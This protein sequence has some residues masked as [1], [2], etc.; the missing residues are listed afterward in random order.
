MEAS[1]AGIYN[2][3][4]VDANLF[5]L[6]HHRAR[7][8]VTILLLREMLFADDAAIASHT[9]E[10]LQ[11][12][13][14]N[15]SRACKEFRVTISIKKTELMCQMTPNEPGITINGKTR[16][17]VHLFKYLGST[18]T[19]NASLDD[20]LDTCIAKAAAVMAKLSKRVWNNK[21]KLTQ[22]TKLQV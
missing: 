2:R 15:L 22:V 5:R 10:G 1:T 16:S 17:N 14:V 8:K 20:E 19:S 9:E 4:R 6:S 12:L 7:T 3:T 18:I 11:R 13:I 21:K